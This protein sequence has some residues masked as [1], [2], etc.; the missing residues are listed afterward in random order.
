[1]GHFQW[2]QVVLSKSLPL[3]EKTTYLMQVFQSLLLLQHE[4]VLRPG[5]ELGQE[6][7]LPT[8]VDLE[9]E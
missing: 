9:H 5:T 7:D 2:E 8:A 4:E 1:M 3:S 6:K